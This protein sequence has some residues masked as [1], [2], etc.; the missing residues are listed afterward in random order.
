MISNSQTLIARQYGSGYTQGINSQPGLMDQYFNLGSIILYDTRV[1]IDGSNLYHF[2]YYHYKVAVQ[3]GGDYDHYARKCKRFFNTLT[4]C[5][6]R[7]YVVF[8]GGYD[9]DDRKL[10]TVL[11]RMENRR[12]RAANICIKGR[13]C[14]LPLLAYETFHLVLKELGIPH[15][16]CVYEADREIA[17]LANK[18]KCP[19]MSND[20][21][22]FVFGMD[23]GFV[24][25]DYMNL[26]LCVFNQETEVASVLE[27][28]QKLGKN[29][30][31]YIPV[32]YYN[33][34]MFTKHFKKSDTSFIL[35]LF[36]TLTGNDYINA[37]ILANFYASIH[38]PKNPSKKGF[39]LNTQTHMLAVLY[40]IDSVESWEYAI[41]HVVGHI[42]SDEKEMVREKVWTSFHSYVNIDDFSDVEIDIILEAQNVK[43]G[44]EIENKDVPKLTDFF[45]QEIPSWFVKKLRNCEITG[46]FLQNVVVNHRVIFN[47]QI[48]ILRELSTYACSRDFRSVIYGVT[49]NSK[50]KENEA[51][52]DSR[53]NSIEEYDRDIKNTKKYYVRPQTSVINDA[54]VQ[55]LPS[56]SQVP[57]LNQSERKN[58]LFGALGFNMSTIDVEN[59]SSLTLLGI[60]SYWIGHAQPQVT[61]SHLWSVILSVFVLHI[62]ALQWLEDKRGFGLQPVVPEMFSDVV[63][64]IENASDKEIDNFMKHMEKN[65]SKP[66]HSS[67]NPQEMRV[68]HGF[69]QFQACLVDVIYL[70][71]VLL[72]PVVIPSP[73]VILNCTFV[74]NLCRD[75]ETRP[76]PD[77]Y[78]EEI[79]TKESPLHRLF[80]LWK[81]SVI[82]LCQSASPDSFDYSNRGT[83]VR[84]KKKSKSG[85]AKKGKRDRVVE[86]AGSDSDSSDKDAETRDELTV[87]CDVNNRFAMLGLD[88]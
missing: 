28:G 52:K 59:D 35:P 58:I 49:M 30:Y 88:E 45:K 73:G 36:A 83:S 16:S 1:I 82:N 24:P 56:I 51:F 54:T 50:R 61:E 6:I 27:P 21:D 15:V 7:P 79:L 86:H 69:S 9:P 31:C 29:E 18:W 20:S 3:Y 19:V 80:L 72:S 64:A 43:A 5:N 68:I 42:K 38:V 41:Q 14:I 55:S 60:L 12:T 70:N 34:E 2:L 40:W 37:S 85:K 71:Q 81:D 47:C 77:F 22:F 13:G 33:Y 39:K 48:E 10:P 32:K 87:N 84:T 76:K 62:R 26:T 63:K 78:S 46:F 8:D 53:K 11:E 65:R 67:K 75:L 74:Y 17:V 25:L 66:D 44:N 57:E 23:G 4:A